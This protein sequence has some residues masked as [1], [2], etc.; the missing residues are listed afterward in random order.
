MNRLILFTIVLVL[1]G[2]SAFS[3]VLAPVPVFA[4]ESNE[5]STPDYTGQITNAVNLIITLILAL[6]P[7]LLV[8]KI[9]DRIFGGLFKGRGSFFF[10]KIRMYVVRVGRALI[11]YI[12][13]RIR[14]YAPYTAYFSLIPFY[15]ILEETSGSSVSIDLSFLYPLINI[16]LLFAILGAIM[17]MMDRMAKGMGN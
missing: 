17:K 4:Q 8:L 1:L 9:I 7:A 12:V 5:T 16:I 11:N 6:I 10:V 15:Y 13:V 2:F 14:A 3:M